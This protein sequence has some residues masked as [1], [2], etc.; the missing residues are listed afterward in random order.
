MPMRAPLDPTIRIQR[1]V[2]DQPI[3]IPGTPHALHHGSDRV[4]GRVG[5]NRISIQLTGS[6]VPRQTTRILLEVHVAGQVVRRTFVPRPYLIEDF[7]WDGLAADGSVA[8]PRQSVLIRIGTTGRGNWPAPANIE[9]RDHRVAIGSWD[10]MRQGLAGWTLDVHHALDR[11][12][13]S[14]WMGDG[15]LRTNLDLGALLNLDPGA[16]VPSADGAQ[17]FVFDADDRH[18]AT[19]DGLTGSTLRRFDY[20]GGRLVAVTDQG[21]TRIERDG[22]GAPT[23]I[24]GP[25]GGRTTLETGPDGSLVGLSDPA[26]GQ[27]RFSY[28]PG[29]LLSGFVDPRG[30]QYGFEYDTDGRLARWTDPAGGATTLARTVDGSQ[31]RVTVSQPG[32]ESTAY[33]QTR[34]AGGGRKRTSDCAGAGLATERIGPNRART[35]TRVDGSSARADVVIDP[36]LPGVERVASSARTTPGGRTLSVQT[37]IETDDDAASP[38]VGR[39]RRERITSGGALWRVAWD[40]GARTV[41][42]GTPEGRESRVRLDDAGRVVAVEVPGRDV[43]R[44]TYDERGRLVAAEQ[45]PWREAWAFDDARRVVTTTDANGGRTEIESDL[46]GRPVQL[47]TAGGGSVRIEYDLAGTPTRVTLPSG[48]VHAFSAGAVGLIERHR[49][50]TGATTIATFDADRQ[51]VEIAFPSGRRIGSRYGTGGRLEAQ[52]FPE[53]A[54]TYGYGSAPDR[55]AHVERTAADGTT[56]RLALAYDGDLLVG[57][58][59][60]GPAAG[61]FTYRLDDAG[62]LAG[63]TLDGGAETPVGRDRDGRIVLDGPVAF[64]RGGSGAEIARVAIGG[65]EIRIQRDGRGRVVGRTVSAAGREVHALAFDYDAADRLIARTERMSG[66]ESRVEFGRDADGR[67][68]RVVGNAGNVAAEY[69]VNGNRTALHRGG[70]VVPS[71]HDADDRLIELAGVGVQVDADG[72]ITGMPDGRRFEYSARGELLGATTPVGERVAYGYD[73]FGRRVSRTSADGTTTAYLYGDP[74]RPLRITAIRTPSGMERLWYDDDGALVVIERGGEQFVVASDQIGTPRA[75]FTIDGTLVAQFDRDVWGSVDRSLMAV[76]WPLE[77]GFGGGIED[78]TTGLVRFGLR[79]YDPSTGRWTALDPAGLGARDWNLYAYCGNDP[80]SLVD[81]SGLGFQTPAQD[82]FYG[83]APSNPVPDSVFRPSL[84]SPNPYS[85]NPWSGPAGTFR[86]WFNNHR[87]WTPDGWGPGPGSGFSICP[88]AGS[89]NRDRFGRGDTPGYE[90]DSWTG[91]QRPQ[92]NWN[93][94]P[95]DSAYG[96]TWGITF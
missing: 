39:G 70:A 14:L 76:G 19:L 53:G 57:M 63:T 35:I 25:F 28:A 54:V 45:G 4:P 78:P 58:T 11:F 65:T 12:G 44:L 9:W 36:L 46:A 29:R 1:Q 17:V 86:S 81:R 20:D 72:F 33:E 66:S 74:D 10:A 95:S 48:G 88:G 2:L 16:G 94:P 7:L 23:A 18:I 55:L 59:W 61:R 92:N 21:T 67:L 93:P 77:I 42:Y 47:T 80:V 22:D 96:T 5:A 51:L 50:A 34:L 87:Y 27:F 6:S 40:P 64:D 84:P 37:V 69:D 24:V 90:N 82:A 56:Q 38:L 31:T 91:Q 8:P 32:G 68:T 41:T 52:T 26:G 62:R 49:S 75:A 71:R 89:L 85:T 79:D 3:P 30:G 15:G 73:G 43:K 60:E 13:S 83:P